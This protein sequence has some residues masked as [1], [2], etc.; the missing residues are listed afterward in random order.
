MAKYDTSIFSQLH[1]LEKPLIP[2][3]DQIEHGDNKGFFGGYH[4]GQPQVVWFDPNG[5]LGYQEW[6]K[7]VKDI[8][9]QQGWTADEP[10]GIA[11]ARTQYHNAK[12]NG[13]VPAQ[14]QP[15]A[16]VAA[17]P[18]G[19]PQGLQAPQ[20][21][22]NSP[23]GNPFAALQ[24]PPANVATTGTAAAPANSTANVATTGTGKE[25]KGKAAQ[26]QKIEVDVDPTNFA[27]KVKCHQRAGTGDD[28]QPVGEIPFEGQYLSN[29][30][31]PLIRF[32]VEQM[33]RLALRKGVEDM[34]KLVTETIQ[35]LYNGDSSPI[36]TGTNAKSKP[37][38]GGKRVGR[39]VRFATEVEVIYEAYAAQFGTKV[40]ASQQ[41]QALTQ[42]QKAFYRSQDW[43]K[44]NYAR[45]ISEGKKATAAPGAQNP[46]LA[47][48]MN[49]V[50][51]GGNPQG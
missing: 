9:N 48:I 35:K 22:G 12:G 46:L 25:P 40:A 43:F 49:S 5:N 41:W 24:T 50:T 17:A 32:A 18:T 13:S 1:T 37:V 14:T 3:F 38:G 34:P 45:K 51:G 42:D 30:A 19:Q 26:T 2:N 29:V 21:T 44:E 28:F 16:N 10:A 36:P 47:N 23:G 15:V 7:T 6:R 31:K 8:I 20:S 27:F 4:N 11:D 39:D 33:L